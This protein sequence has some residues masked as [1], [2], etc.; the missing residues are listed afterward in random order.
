VPIWVVALDLAYTQ[1]L[2][3]D[4]AAA[5]TLQRA[6][7]HRPPA[8]PAG[9]PLDA[10]AAYLALRLAQGSDEAPAVRAA[11]RELARVQGREAR[12]GQAGRGSLGGAFI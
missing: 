3:N 2:M 12:P 6:A 4:P 8:M 9:H 5:A 11:L 10:V 1:V 7:R